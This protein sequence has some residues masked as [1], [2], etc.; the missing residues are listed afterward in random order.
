MGMVPST[1]PRDA[2][3]SSQTRLRPRADLLYAQV[4]KQRRRGRVIAVRTQVVFGDPAVVTA[5]LAQSP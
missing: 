2:W 4:I 5:R 3:R 1:P